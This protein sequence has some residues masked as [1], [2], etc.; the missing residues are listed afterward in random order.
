MAFAF[1]ILISIDLDQPTFGGLVVKNRYSCYDKTNTISRSPI[2]VKVS[3]SKGSIS[4]PHVIH[5]LCYRS[6]L[7]R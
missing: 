2:L 5:H 1:D 6:S 4:H 7:R 3:C